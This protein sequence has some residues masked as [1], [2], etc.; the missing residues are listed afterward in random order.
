MSDS[1]VKA[2]DLLYAV[3][4]THHAR[5]NAQ[6]LCV[7]ETPVVN[8][9]EE[10][11]TVSFDLEDARPYLGFPHWTYK[12]Y[13]LGINVHRSAAEALRRFIVEA[14]VRHD[15]AVHALNR[16]ESEIQWARAQL[17]PLAV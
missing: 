5:W 1:T 16:A 2:G 13:E 8:V 12:S 10:N 17:S 11:G 14:Q 3:G 4:P 6:D 7:Y 9:R 15:A